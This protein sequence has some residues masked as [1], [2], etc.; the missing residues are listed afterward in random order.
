MKSGG[1]AMWFCGYEWSS[2]SC[3]VYLVYLGCGWYCVSFCGCDLKKSCFIKSI[4]SRDWFD[5]YICLV[6]TVVEIEIE[7]KNSLYYI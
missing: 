7:Q 5:I 3:I 6:K 1:G 4:F 2:I